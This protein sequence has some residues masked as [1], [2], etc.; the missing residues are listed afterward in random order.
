MIYSRRGPGRLRR[1]VAALAVLMI[2]L[3]ACATADP[4][5]GPTEA[6]RSATPGA[7]TPVTPSSEESGTAPQD[8]AVSD[9]DEGAVAEQVSPLGEALGVAQD[10]IALANE[11]YLIE[12][13][14]LTQQCMTEAGFEY[15]PT[16]GGVDLANRRLL[17]LQDSLTQDRFTEQYGFGI[18]TL[19]ELNFQGEGV[20]NFVNQQFG[21]PPS[22]E[23]S[24]GEQEAYEMALS[25]RIIQG[26]NAEQAQQE[27][28]NNVDAALPGS[29]RRFGFD[30]ADNPG[31]VFDDFFAILGDEWADLSERFESD[32][33]IREAMA[34]WQTCMAE[35][36]H[37]YDDRFE[38]FDELQGRANALANQ[39]LSSS[40]VL[41]ALGEAQQQGFTSM[42]SEERS[43]F[44][45]DI[46]ALQGFSWV[47]EIQSEF[48][49]LINFELTVAGDS[50][51]CLDEELL[52]EVQF[53]LERDFVEEHI[54][55][56]AVLSA[57]SN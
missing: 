29:C 16:S 36:G 43:T 15:M 13:E 6:P 37:G 4:S 20:I 2:M 3:G 25:G 11:N 57:A 54:A 22:T 55:Q 44:L 34:Q 42:S 10:E 49:Q 45:E 51:D 46:G 35:R 1:F 38:I 30:N 33:R 9:D 21:P 18:T 31:E 41:V 28:F 14:E 39:Y 48:D 40:T 8:S 47:P 27:I 17:E 26:L 53:E 52:E 7:D 50:A 19:F 5:D 23:R 24:A 56:L 32:P 12:V